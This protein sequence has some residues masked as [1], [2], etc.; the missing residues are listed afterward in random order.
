MKGTS[1]MP[2][3]Q[4]PTRPR[5]LV[6]ALVC[7]ALA[8]TLAACSSWSSSGADKKSAG[9]TRSSPDKTATVRIKNR[10][11]TTTVTGVPKR[12]VSLTPQWTDTLLAMGA[13]PIA[14]VTSSQYLDGPLPWEGELSKG[15]QPIDMTSTELPM[16]KIAALKPDLIL[17]SFLIPDA[18][19]YA[20]LSKIAPT[21]GPLT[22]REVDHWQDLVTTAGKFL[23]DPDEATKVISTFDA[24]IAA[25]AKALPGLEGKT[26]MLAYYLPGDGINVVADPDDGATTMFEALGLKLDPDIAASDEAGTG[27]VKL[28]F[29]N[30]AKLDADLLLVAGFQGSDPTEMV[31]W[32][33]L[34]AVEA[35]TAQILDT[36]TMFALNTPSSL[37]LAY[38]LDQVRPTLTKLAGS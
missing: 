17:G 16:G 20:T 22:D 21:I 28:S 26:F 24:D 11:G 23:G 29:E 35:G 12:I 10:F 33:K 31:G 38:A 6:G 9:G 2:T 37:G 27:R 34:P 8:S 13:Q 14:H 7:V 3:P 25:T 15:S 30:V 36:A 4:R 5:R 19:T 32:S 18:E 1:I